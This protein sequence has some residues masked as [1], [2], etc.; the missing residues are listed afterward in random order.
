MTLVD[1][2]VSKS[3]ESLN[4]RDPNLIKVTYLQGSGY[5]LQTNITKNPNNNLNNSRANANTAEPEFA[6]T[7]E[8]STVIFR[9]NTEL[10]KTGISL[11]AMEDNASTSTASETGEIFV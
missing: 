11:E 5:F 9:S 8:S 1:L 6:T 3:D 10:E 4:Q 7:L 2:S